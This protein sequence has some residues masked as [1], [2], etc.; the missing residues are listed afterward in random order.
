MAIFRYKMQNILNIKNQLE[1]QAKM[2]FGQARMRLTEEEEKLHGLYDRK[3]GYLEEGVRMRSQAIVARDLRANKNALEKMDEL[4]KAQVLQ[5]RLA[6]RNLEN[7]RVKMQEAMVDRKTHEKLRERAFD[8]FMAE[9]RAQETKEI[10]EL[11]S[12]TYGNAKKE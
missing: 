2:Q 4:I 1:T 8:E 3:N 12:Y 7:A 5:V 11:T 6:Q 10:D 9:E